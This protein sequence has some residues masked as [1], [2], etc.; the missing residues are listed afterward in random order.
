[1]GRRA[2][3]PRRI[4]P[5]R[6][7]GVELEGSKKGARGG[8]L[9]IAL[10]FVRP[11]ARQKTRF[12]SR[13]EGH[14]N[15]KIYILVLAA[16][17]AGAIIATAPHRGV[18]EPFPSPL[19]FR[20]IIFHPDL[21]QISGGAKTHFNWGSWRRLRGCEAVSWPRGPRLVRTSGIVA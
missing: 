12:P 16:A 19:P 21:L 10:A 15:W 5:R 14:S 6:K 13:V 3:S 7:R 11:S 8:R 2:S 17:A 20:E 4:L 9:D 18:D 1:M